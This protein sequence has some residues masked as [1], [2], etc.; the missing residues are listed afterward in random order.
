[1]VQPCQENSMRSVLT[2]LLLATAATTASARDWE[3]QVTRAAQANFPEYLEL[4]AI[5][6]VA[7]Q[8]ADIQRNAAFLQAALQRRGFHTQLM[9]NPASRPEVFARWDSTTKAAKTILFYIHFDGQP[10]IAEEWSQG[11]PFLPVVKQRDAQGTWREVPRDRLLA[12]PLDPELRVFARAAADDKAPIMMFLTAIDLMRSQGRSPPYNIKLILDSEEETGSPSLAGVVGAN[13]TLLAADAVVILDDPSHASGRPTLA[14]GNRGIAQAT[15]V[16]YG[17][18]TPLHSGHFGNFVPNPAFALAR[19]LVSMKGEDGRVLIPGYYDGIALTAAERAVLA[20]TGD[21]EPALLKRAGIAR[22]ESVGPTYQEALQYPSLNVRGMAA[23]AVGAKAAN[24]IP[25][26]ATVELDL[27][28]TPEA[29]GQR[30]FGLVRRYIESQ[31]YRLTEGPPSDQERARYDKL[32]SF[33][34]HSVQAAERIPMDSTPGQWAYRAIISATGPSPGTVPARIRMLGGTDPTDILV[35]ALHLPF[36]V[37]P[38][39]NADN[40]QHTHDENLRIGNFISGT[41]SIYSLLVTP[42]P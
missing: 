13:P 41:Q 14:F 18:R 2:C 33:T 32:A 34:L 3:E 39:V 4:L 9:S 28:S 31:G 23:G 11:S 16:V 17:P 6:D 27:R 35:N 1:M 21:D 8:P 30:L 5:P 7:D 36:I 20:A 29:D 38:T 15:L 24:I 26:E 12:T 22:P 42:Y 40:N 37:V 10:V 25:D 19:L